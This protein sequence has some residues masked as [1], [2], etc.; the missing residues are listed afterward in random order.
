MK[1]ELEPIGHVR[2]TRADPVDDNWDAETTTIEL[3]ARR[4][5]PDAL[6]SLDNFSHVEVIYWFHHPEAETPNLGARRPRGRADWP[7]VGI[8]AQRA[9]NRPNRLGLTVCKIL[10]VDGLKLQ[11]SGL[12]AIDGTPV[13]DLK[14]WMEGFAPRGEVREPQWA[15]ELM[16]G[17]W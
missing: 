7:P 14:P 9:K 10:K 17:Y 2:T 6:L 11:V 3:D 15:R 5:T 4:F 1:I 12:D 8:F 16:A 13:L